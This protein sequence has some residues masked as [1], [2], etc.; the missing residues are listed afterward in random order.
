MLLTLLLSASISTAPGTQDPGSLPSSLP[1]PLLQNAG[2]VLSAGDAGQARAL[3]LR[4]LERDPNDLTTLDLLGNASLALRDTDTA[5]HCWHCWLDRFDLRPRPGSARALRAELL[6]KLLPVDPEAETWTKLQADYVRNL[7]ALAR[8]YRQR[9]DLLSSIE[10]FSQILEVEPGNEDAARA[11]SEIRRTGGREVAVEDAFAGGD[12]SGGLSQEQIAVLDL[13]HKEWDKAFVKETDNYKYRTDAG[14]LVLET[15]AIAMEQMNRFYRRFFRFKEDGSKTPKIEIRIFK[16][17]DEYLKLGRNPVEWSAGH[18]IGDAVETYCGGVSGKASALEM[19]R[20]LFHEAAHQ[21]VSL[22]G[23]FVPGWLNE[24]YASFFEGCVILSNGTVKANRAPSERLFQLA[25]RMEKGWMQDA[26][27]GVKDAAGQWASPEL[28]PRLSTVVSGGYEWGPPWYAPTWGVVYFLYNYRD[29]KGRLVYRDALHEY[30]TSFKRGEARDPVAHFEQVVLKGPLSK[31]K[32]IRELDEVWKAFVLALRDRETGKTSAADELVR[33]ADQ[34][35]ALGDGAQAL[36]LYEEARE[37]RPDDTGLLEKLAK[38]LEERKLLARAADVWRDLK[39]ELELRGGEATPLLE[40]ARKKVL[41]LDP[42]A[43]AYVRMKLTLAERGIALARGYE[44]REL[45]TMALEIA[46]RM[47]ASFSIPEALQLYT[48]IAERTKKSLARWRLAYDEKSLA[49]WTGGDG[50]YQAYGSLIRADVPD[51]RSDVP[52]GGIRTRE[53]LCDVTFDADFSLETELRIPP[54]EGD[55]PAGSLAGLCFGRKGTKDFHAV[56]L[57]E[58][59]FLDIATSRGGTTWEFL[60]HRQCPVGRDWHTLRIDVTGKS[61]DV[62]YDGYYVRS[63]E[64]GSEASVRGAFGLITGPGQAHFR[65]I[66]LLARERYDPAARIERRLAMQKVSSGEL[67]R[68]PG[69][70]SGIRPPE[71]A[72]GTLLQGERT[73]LDALHGR[74]TLLAFWTPAVE[75]KIP[76]A[77]WFADLQ[78]RGK[79]KGLA[80]LVIC[81]SG[82]HP[83]SVSA[84]LAQSPMPGVTVAID[85]ENKTFAAYWIQA[86]GFGMPRVVLLDRDGKV[87]FEGDPG[88]KAGIGWRKEDG[89][90]FVDAALDKLLSS[91]S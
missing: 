45:P 43:R 90:T 23:P 34:A 38:L 17:R 11:I 71:L 8:D 89:P 9:K 20:T 88:F 63:L 65:H 54:G 73:T 84:V 91:G 50:S 30:Y 58:K 37:A 31:H 18:F 41:D 27:D 74:P 80:L 56:V 19:Y 70:F 42:L 1:S 13:A 62:Y 12:P 2:G 53:L 87:V 69:T 61:L 29:E 48:E 75:Q 24:G 66:R 57:H 60:D 82:T 76:C 81:D 79:G 52:E 3:L 36:E 78:E 6:K 28:A 72:L 47:S 14:Y 46:R 4:A 64:F 33:I 67:K 16:N 83:E 44:K 15:S 77:K 5:V 68:Q 21:F 35:A 51:D 7:L 40:R 26:S 49:G 32:T 22:T 85:A 10:V 59:G 86:G 55:K 39:R 25:A